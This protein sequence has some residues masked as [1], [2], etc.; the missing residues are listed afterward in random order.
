MRSP[1]S[2]SKPRTC[3]ADQ[4]EDLAGVLY[5]MPNHC[6]PTRVESPKTF[7]NIIHA[8]QQKRIG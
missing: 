2:Q 7:A 6:T 5:G 8:Y 4:C 3:F 1:G